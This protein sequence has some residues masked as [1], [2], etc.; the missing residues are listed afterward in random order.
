MLILGATGNIGSFL[1]QKLQEQ[2]AD[3]I[4]GA[5]AAD[6]IRLNRLGVRAV[7][8]D[9][10]DFASLVNAMQGVEKV[11]MLLPMEERMIEWANNIVNA[12]IKS[13]VKFIL[14]SSVID[15]SPDSGYALFRVHGQ[16][17]RLVR[18]SGI[19]YCITHPNSFMQNFAVYYREAISTDDAFYFSHGSA[20]IS[21]I[22]VRDIALANA[23]ILLHSPA[24][25]NTEY[26]LTGPEALI[27]ERI[28]ELLSAAAGRTIRRVELSESQYTRSLRTMGMTEWDIDVTLSLERHIR[29][30]RQSR[31]SHDVEHLT[32]KKPG[33]FAQFARDY[34]A[35]W[36][37]VP[38]YA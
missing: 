32:G 14:R 31:I 3:F 17:D 22:D 33:T 19:T 8:L 7:E 34:A 13:N 1:V 29:D 10:G 9:F 38:A 4:A 15:A 24:H 26:D 35:S 21:Y 5:P 36:K 12:A 11:F 20:P 23:Q 6:L 16:I 2:A 27:D 25:L 28:A 37:K 30:Y 18:Q